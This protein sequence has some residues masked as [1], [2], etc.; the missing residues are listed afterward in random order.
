MPALKYSTGSIGKKLGNFFKNE[1]KEDKKPD[2]EGK[3]EWSS[4]I[5]FFLSALGYAG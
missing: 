3:E 4:N 2:N 5:D 1:K